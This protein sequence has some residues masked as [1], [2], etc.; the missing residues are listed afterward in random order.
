MTAGNLLQLLKDT[1]RD[2]LKVKAPRLAAALAYYTAFSL[3]PLLII[4]IGI[5]GLV[6]GREAAQGQILGPLQGVLGPQGGHTLQSLIA[7]SSKPSSGI[8]ATIIGLV[9]LVLGAS[10]VFGQLQEALNTIWEVPAK[11]AGGIWHAIRERFLSFGMVLGVAFLLLVSLVISTGLAALGKFV[12]H[13]FPSLVILT[14]ILSFLISWAVISTLFAVIFKYLPDAEIAWKDVWIGAFVTGL[15]FMVGQMLISLYIGHS[16]MASTYGAAAS[17]L[18]IL[19]WVYYSAQI[20][21]FGA[22][23]TR[24]YAK[25]YGS[26]AQAGRTQA[27]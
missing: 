15:L 4:L 20:L 21:L 24:V 11:A 26:H 23:F 10:G 8:L 13:A 5:A 16:A 27:A 1:V 22:E 9:T 19:V 7:A 3:A 25:Q 12:G 2:W 17:L 18:I 14:T 6:F